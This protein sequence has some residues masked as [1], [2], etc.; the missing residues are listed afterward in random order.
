MKILFIHTFYRDQG[1]E[2]VLVATEMALLKEAGF[3]VELLAF[4]NPTS[5]V[6]TLLTLFALPF[7]VF[8]FLKTIRK[9][10][11]FQP[12]V[13]HLHNWHFAASPSVIV[14]SQVAKVPIVLSLHNFRLICPSGILFYNGQVF[15]ESLTQ[16]FPWKAVRLGVY[17]NSFLQTF[18]LA[19]TIFLHKKLGTWQKVD[20]FVVNSEFEKNTFL[21]STLGIPEHKLKIKANSLPEPLFDEDI[22]RQNH[23]LFIGRL[24]AEKGVEVLMEAFSK[25][26]F[27]L[28]MYG[29]GPLEQKVKS[30][31]DQH[32]NI[33]FKGS[34][35][36]EQMSNELRKCTALIFPSTWFEGMPM[37]L[38]HTFSTGTPV[39]ASKIGAMSTMI[40]DH[41]NG[42]HFE[43]GNSEDLVQKLTYWN[44]LTDHEKEEYEHRSRNV[45]ETTYTPQANRQSLE[46][47]YQAVINQ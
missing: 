41:H 45:Y 27:Q 38:V 17:R 47:I 20:A 21:K 26:N 40:M 29:Y 9:I 42:L 18:W 35:A 4:R 8:S 7:N 32:H 12:D 6:S 33:Q 34:L 28:V 23:F 30:F 14:A 1:G 2:E 13:V 5:L 22:K 43:V 39:I 10:R 36:H 3:E 16:S 37:T 25:T 11:S 31:A 24:V 46:S 44:S 15:L 19:F